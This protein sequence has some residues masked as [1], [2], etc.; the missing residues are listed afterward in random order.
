MIKLTLYND[1]D[2]IVNAELIETIEKTPD[3]IVSLVTGKKLMV[4]ESVE[5]VISKVIMYRRLI[6]RNQRL[7]GQKGNSYLRSEV[8]NLEQWT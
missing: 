1:S 4:K 2:V 7:F 6:A 3:T 8:R 5:N